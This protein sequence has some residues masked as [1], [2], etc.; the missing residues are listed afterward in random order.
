MVETVQPDSRTF[1][2]IE[3]NASAAGSYNGDGV[4]RH[5]RQVND[6]RVLRDFGR[7]RD[8]DRWTAPP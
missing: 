3:G 7:P 4:Y 6:G 8:T 1:T 2:T 5:T